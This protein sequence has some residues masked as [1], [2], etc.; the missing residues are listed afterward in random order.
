MQFSF[1]QVAPG[2]KGWHTQS[3]SCCLDQWHW[4]KRPCSRSLPVLG[5]AEFYQICSA[6]FQ[7]LLA[8]D[9]LVLLS[10]CSCQQARV[11]YY[12][13]LYQVLPTSL[14]VILNCVHC[15][16]TRRRCFSRAR[17]CFQK[18][19]YSNATGNDISSRRS[20]V[21]TDTM[22]IFYFGMLQPNIHYCQK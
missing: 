5:Q 14:S 22:P 8:V 1:F 20:S 16:C 3:T 15:P 4:N 10:K 6:K 11:T 21:N 13:T 17:M 9:L 12:Y 18:S 7:Q 2:N 19:F